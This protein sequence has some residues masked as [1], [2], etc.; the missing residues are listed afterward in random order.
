MYY[1]VSYR[2]VGDGEER[3]VSV[4][5]IIELQVLIDRLLR[6]SRSVETILI[7]PKPLSVS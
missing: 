1:V 6:G 4:Y 7:A 5:T 3:K 2:Y